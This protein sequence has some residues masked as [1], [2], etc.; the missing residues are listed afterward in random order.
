MIIEAFNAKG[1][2]VK[3]IIAGGGLTKN[4]MLMQIYADILGLEMAVTGAEQV[5]AL[6]AAMLG[7][8]A[9]GKQ[10]GGYENLSDA[11]M[12][13]GQPHAMV[14][15]PN[16]AHAEIYSALFKEY[17]RLYDYFGRGENQVMQNLLKIKKNVRK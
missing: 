3:S 11:A 12:S 17:A 10:N 15:K 16:P 5:S 6:G 7:S 14:Y 4:Q 9:A 8:V 2:P 13:M 1:I